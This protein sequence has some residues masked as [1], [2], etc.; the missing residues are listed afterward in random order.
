MLCAQ[1][2]RLSAPADEPERR[3]GIFDT[4]LAKNQTALTPVER[5]TLAGL[6]LVYENEPGFEV[7]S[8]AIRAL[9][10]EVHTDP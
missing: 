8:R 7:R 10:P 9:L 2:T 4:L 5:A 1:N 3:Q 6:A